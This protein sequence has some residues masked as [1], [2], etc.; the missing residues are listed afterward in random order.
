MSGFS[1]A[2]IGLM[3][4]T[5]GNVAAAARLDELGLAPP[6]HSQAVVRWPKKTLEAA[7]ASLYPEEFFQGSSSPKWRG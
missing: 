2:A 6:M 5:V 4:A 1:V 3:A 7:F